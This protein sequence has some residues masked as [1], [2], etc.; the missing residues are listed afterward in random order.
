M[1]TL[2]SS[3]RLNVHCELRCIPSTPSGQSDSR[4]Y[5][6]TDVTRILFIMYYTYAWS[7]H[8]KIRFGLCPSIVYSSTSVFVRPIVCSLTSGV[9]NG[10]NNFLHLHFQENRLTD[11][12]QTFG[13]CSS[14]QNVDLKNF[15]ACWVIFCGGHLGFCQ[16][17]VKL[18]CQRI[19]RKT[20]WWIDVKPSGIVPQTETS[21]WLIFGHAG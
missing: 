2:S 8:C 6:C 7:Y 13:D 18:S 20:V 5:L 15:W 14:D 11:W 12:H 21:T 4:S 10:V 1:A 16:N 3:C 19:S 9:N 17:R